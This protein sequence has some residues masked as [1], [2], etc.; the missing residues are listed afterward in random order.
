MNTNNDGLIS[1]IRS[2][3]LSGFSH[4]G[5]RNLYETF[6]YDQE[7]EVKQIEAM[8]YRNDI[9]NRIVRA[10]PQAT[11]R[12]EAIISDDDGDSD[13]TSYFVKNANDFISKNKIYHY[14]ERFDR[15]SGLGEYAI[16]MM[17]FNDDDDLN[18]PLQD[19]DHELLYVQPYKETSAQITKY[20][21]NPKD[22]RFG[23]PE[24]YTINPRKDANKRQ[25]HALN[26]FN[27]HHSRVIHV[28]EFL[29]EDDVFGTP[30][31]MPIY[32]RLMDLEKVVGG[33]SE[34]FW[35]NGRGGV[36][37][38]VDKDAN[39]DEAA[40]D[41]MKEHAEEYEH[42]LRRF[43][44]GKGLTVSPISINVPDPKPNVDVL[45]DLISGTVGIPKRILTG[46]E[47]G[48]LSSSQ[49]ENNFASRVDERRTTFAAPMI[50]E[51]FI[52]KM[53]DTGNITKPNGTFKACWESDA[54]LNEMQKAD[55]MTKKTQ[56]VATY[57][58][59]ASSDIMPVGEFREKILGLEPEI[60]FEA[61]PPMFD[62]DED[63]DLDFK[64][65]EGDLDENENSEDKTS[66]D[67]DN[68]QDQDGEDDQEIE[69]DEELFQNFKQL[70]FMSGSNVKMPMQ[71]TT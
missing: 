62:E 65:D 14:L 16:L 51:A 69:D 17:V 21:T 8:Y 53:I 34:M 50:L 52:Q 1:R 54:G 49:D 9:A 5:N 22:P 40:R 61:Y 66:S 48:E 18:E 47:R 20:V 64:D 33:S 43:M 59:S 2:A 6:G 4:K 7:I 25:S 57:S 35:Q 19:G 42:E 56:A 70:A 29:D 63:L 24:I 27:V 38:S 31:L 58:N 71:H 39:Y 44:I 15:L 60:D 26:S 68:N 23:L 46:S 37:M 30:R 36:V 55:I 32:N 11:W 41:K 67:E 12:E 28:S 45:L 10:F 13:E 3:A